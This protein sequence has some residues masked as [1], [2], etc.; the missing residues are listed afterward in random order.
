MNELK[1][2]WQLEVYAKRISDL[3]AD[4][5]GEN[6]LD[7]DE[8]DFDFLQKMTWEVDKLNDKIQQYYVNLEEQVK[9]SA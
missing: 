7:W 6:Y 9:K 5:S 4:L 3:L 2:L 8:E 1:R